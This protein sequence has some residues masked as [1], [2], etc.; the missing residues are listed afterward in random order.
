MAKKELTSDVSKLIPD[1]LF[2]VANFKDLK[3][4]LIAIKDKINKKSPCAPFELSKKLY[5]IKFFSK[6]PFLSETTSDDCNEGHLAR[7][8]QYDL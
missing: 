6:I 3:K 5:F 4:L 2:A 1:H 7:L 8:A